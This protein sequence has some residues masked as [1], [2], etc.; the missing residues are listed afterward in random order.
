MSRWMF[1]G[2]NAFITCYARRLF[3]FLI[4]FLPC[5]IVQQEIA[6]IIYTSYDFNEL[7]I[8]HLH[9]VNG[10]HHKRNSLISGISGTCLSLYCTL[11]RVHATPSSLT[12]TTNF[13]TKSDQSLSMLSLPPASAYTGRM[14]N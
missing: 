8:A 13:D 9:D 2:R 5:I 14:I 3:V 11:D 12:S 4:L 1:G 7:S 10:H 6:F